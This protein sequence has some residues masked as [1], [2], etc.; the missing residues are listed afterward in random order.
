VLRLPLDEGGGGYTVDAVTGL[1]ET[2]IAG[3]WVPGRHGSA[4]SFAE[5]GALTRRV[6]RQQYN[7]NNGAAFASIM[8]TDLFGYA[9]DGQRAALRDPATPRGV[10]ATLRGLAWKGGLYSLTSTRTGVALAPWRRQPS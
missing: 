6:S 8:L 3:S 1:E 5:S 4:L 2:L 10:T 7:E 9:P